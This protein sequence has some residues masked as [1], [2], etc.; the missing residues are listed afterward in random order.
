MNRRRNEG[1]ETF[2]RLLDWTRGQAAAERLAV[3]LLRVEG[4]K[5]IDPSHPLGG[6]DGLKDVLCQRDGKRWIGGIYFP[7]GQ[8]TI[9]KIKEKLKQDLLGVA[10]CSAEGFAFVTNQELR[11]SE[12]GELRNLGAGTEIELLHLERIA[13][14]LDSPQCYGIR[15][16]FLDIEMT[17]EEQIAFNAARDAIIERLQHTLES[18]VS[19]LRNPDLLKSLSSDQ[20]RASVPLSEIKEFKSILDSIAGYNPYVVS[21]FS[22]GQTGHIRDLQVPLRELREFADILDRIAGHQSSLTSMTSI[23]LLGAVPGHVSQLRVPLADMK[24]F[25]TILERLAGHPSVLRA[26]IGHS[27]SGHVT[28][29]NVPINEL[30]QY[31]ATLDRVIEKLR[32]KKHLE[33]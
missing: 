26:A 21:A 5:S 15:L 14:M 13:S 2:A 25:A 32:A 31:E 9:G 27:L 8:R 30:Q 3:Q 18:L 16:E 24:E 1:A 20:I 7:R 4:F 10:D 33:S 6:P 11:L 12:R 29:L 17:K 23:A 28:D 19:Q 22:F